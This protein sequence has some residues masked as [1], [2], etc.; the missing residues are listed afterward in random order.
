MHKSGVK[1]RDIKY[2]S[3]KNEDKIYIVHSDDARKFARQLEEDKS[4]ESYSVCKSLE[5]ER[6][7]QISKIDIRKEFFEQAWESD[8]YIVYTT[9]SVAIREI[10]SSSCLTKHS[11][12]VK[13]ELS[14]R[15]WASV[16]VSDWKVVVIGG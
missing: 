9:K 4:V 13:L 7:A 12:I 10:C 3:R 5:Q 14:R 11:E 2:L 16:G 15:Y 8:F 6:L 1:R